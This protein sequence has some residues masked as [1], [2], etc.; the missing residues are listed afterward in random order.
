MKHLLLLVTILYPLTII[1]QED[2]EIRTDSSVITT[3][4]FKYLNSIRVFNELEN[5][6][7]TYYTD[8]Y[9]DTKKTK[10][11]GIFNEDNDY[12]GIS[13]IYS[14]EGKVITETNHDLGIWT[15][16]IEEDYPFYQIQNKIKLKADS[17]IKSIYG[18][19]FFNKYVTW[20]IDGSAIYNKNES[21]NWVDKFTNEPKTFLF[22][23]NIRFDREHI[24][25]GIIE[26]ELDSTG[27][28]IPNPYERIYGFEEVPSNIEKDFKL[29]FSKAIDKAKEEGLVE[30][31]SNKAIAFLK[32]E[33]LQKPKLYNGC[34]RFYV[35]IK[36]DQIK[37]IVP[38]GRSSITEKFVVYSFN[39][40]TG[41]FIE[42]KKMKS[43]KSWEKYSGNS[44]G[45][46]EDK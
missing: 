11:E 21:G 32:W 38:E 13:K 19:E 9:Y 27:H 31:D 34:F 8:Y 28:F 16:K 25:R 10:E 5:K 22:R 29:N 33:G 1:A 18:D 26:F 39:P 12:I 45:L 36:T 43:V 46:I 6:T 17:L 37:N 14:P 4:Y 40:W 30:S 41:Y 20:K 15:V 42:K 44:T 2:K 23:Y 24:Y 7:K 3:K 35:I